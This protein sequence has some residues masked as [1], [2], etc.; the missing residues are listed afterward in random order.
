MSP[1]FSKR[2]YSWNSFTFPA[3]GDC[4]AR[5]SILEGEIKPI[6]Q[7]LLDWHLALWVARTQRKLYEDQ[8]PDI[9]PLSDAERAH[10][11][12]QREANLRVQDAII[13]RIES[14]Y[15]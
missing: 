5:W 6:I 15:T 12:S 9:S 8:M 2:T 10:I 11:V 7:R 14:A 1:K 13:S 4:N 3:C